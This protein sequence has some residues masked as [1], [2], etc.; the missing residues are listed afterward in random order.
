MWAGVGSVCESE[1]N[2]FLLDRH[3]KIIIGLFYKEVWNLELEN[4]PANKMTFDFA[5]HR[6]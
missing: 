5:H 3:R 6:I 4:E 2:F 1:R